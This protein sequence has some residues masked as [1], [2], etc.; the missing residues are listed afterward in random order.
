MQSKARKLASLAHYLPTRRFAL[1][2]AGLRVSASRWSVTVQ[3]L[4]RTSGLIWLT[5]PPPSQAGPA[6]GL[7]ERTT[8]RRSNIWRTCFRYP[9]LP[10]WHASTVTFPNVAT[11]KQAALPS[12]RRPWAASA[13]VASVSQRHGRWRRLPPCSRART[14]RAW[15]LRHRR[16]IVHTDGVCLTLSSRAT[17]SSSPSACTIQVP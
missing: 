17:T 16:H 12:R 4:A 7:E 13:E 3:H 1:I 11:L 14:T 2:S 6:R 15:L 10:V 8:G 9:G 5:P